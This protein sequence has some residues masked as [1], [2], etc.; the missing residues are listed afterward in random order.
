MSTKIEWCDETINPIQDKRKGKSGRGYHCT[1]CSPG[2]LNCYAEQ[3]NK[4]R[5]NGKPFDNSPVEFELLQSEINKLFKGRKP[6]SFFIQS[7]GDI[8]HKDVPLS[9]IERLFKVFDFLAMDL[10]STKQT[11]IV[12]TKQAARMSES[13]SMINLNADYSW[14]EIF[15]DHIYLGLTVCNQAEWDEKGKI[16]L[17]IPGNKIISHEPALETIHYGEGLSQIKVLISGGENAHGARPSWPDTFRADRDQ[18]AE[19]GIDF[20]FK[21]YGNYKGEKDWTIPSGRL[22]DG[23]EHNDLPWMK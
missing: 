20:F 3:I 23:I 1:K 15:H 14:D 16:F 2:C 21:G 5:G 12:L 22:L 6:K 11:V 8:F 4:I 9:F 13:L 19:A 10:G 17:Q 7:M 18:C